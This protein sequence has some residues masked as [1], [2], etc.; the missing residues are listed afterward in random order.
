INYNLA[1]LPTLFLGL[2]LDFNVPPSELTRFQNEVTCTDDFWSIPGLIHY[3]TP[4][5]SPVFSEAISDTIVYW[6]RQ[7]GILNGLQNSN[8]KATVNYYPNPFNAS[9][10]FTL[11][12]EANSPVKI[13][14]LSMFGREVYRSEVQKDE[15]NQPKALNLDFLPAGVYWIRLQ[16]NGLNS[17][18]KVL[19]Q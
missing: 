12:I 15:D 4:N 1:N 19:K 18:S 6:L 16:G 17:V 14:V 3:M 13:S 2:G 5:N 11:P 9:I 7:P 8:Q 10:S